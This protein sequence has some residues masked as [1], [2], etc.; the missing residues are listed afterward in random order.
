[1]TRVASQP[2]PHDP[3]GE[4]RRTPASREVTQEE[5]ELIPNKEQYQPGDVAEILVQ[6]PFSPAEGLLTVARSGILYTERF[7]IDEEF[8]HPACPY[9]RCLHSQ[10]LLQVDLNGAAPRVNDQGEPVEG[11][12]SRPAFAT[13]SMI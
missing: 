6:A 5:V 11:V 1:M 12:P 10:H 13:G 2:Q 4:W 8:D 9:R 7:T 3:L